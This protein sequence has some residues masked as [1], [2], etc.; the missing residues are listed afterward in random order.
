MGHRMSSLP[1][2]QYCGKSPTISVGAGR[3]A[4]MSTG[5]HAQCETLST[6]K[7]TAAHRAKLEALTSEERKEIE[8][9]HKP[10]P[11]E[12]L[13]HKLNYRDA[14]TEFEVGLDLVGSFS[15][16][17]T[18][19]ILTLGHVDMFWNIRTKV[20]SEALVKVVVVG[21]IKKS[22]W[23]CPEGPDD[24]LQLQAYGHSLAQRHNADWFLP[25]LW[26]A[27]DGFWVIGKPH[28]MFGMAAASRWS[29]IQA[30]ASN[31]STEFSHGPHCDG[32]YSRLNCPAHMVRYDDVLVVPGTLETELDN[33]GVLGILESAKRY[34]DTAKAQ[35]EYAK[36]WV[37]RNGPVSDGNGKEW[38]PSTVTG[39]ES[40][41]SVKRL[42]EAMGEHAEAY[43][44]RGSPSIQ[45]RWTK[46]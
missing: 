45:N 34:D 44:S 40:V 25:A 9:W 46:S 43:I 21:D 31:D 33:D 30:A 36:Q 35:K 27:E 7:G 18:H 4:A 38:G 19:D 42:R 5:F 10:E 24:S 41:M 1:M 15:T 26:I 39:R 13:N 23:T 11:L 32:C 28:S 8:T 14:T 12:A 22:R 6:G 20:D 29:R 37:R 3:A 16:D 2:A 17:P